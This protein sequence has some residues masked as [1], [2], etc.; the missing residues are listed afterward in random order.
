[1]SAAGRAPV[2]VLAHQKGLFS[3]R[4]RVRFSHCDPAGIV[5]FPRWFDLLNGVV[6][7]WF[8]DGLCLDY[9][10]FHEERGIGLGYGHAAADFFRPG[11]W[12][13]RLDVFLRVARIGGASLELALTAFRDAEPVLAARLVIV[14]TALAE[15][16]A[17]PLPYDLRAAAE[18]YRDAQP[19]NH[20]S[21]DCP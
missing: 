12:N 18:R 9:R 4:V 15:R 2:P 1:M 19:Q 13:D 5:Y 20:A 6:E 8:T 21:G 7:D 16:H 11:F 3:M 17:I 10:G 14:T